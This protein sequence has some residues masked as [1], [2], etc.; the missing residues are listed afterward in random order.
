MTNYS[1]QSVG[2]IFIITGSVTYNIL[3]IGFTVIDMDVLDNEQLLLVK[4]GLQ[5]NYLVSPD[6]VD[7]LAYIA[8]NAIESG[9][10]SP[11]QI[12]DSIGAIIIGQNGAQVTY[13]D[14]GNQIVIEVPTLDDKVDKV[15]G[16]GLSQNDYTD[17]IADL[18]EV[19]TRVFN[20][21]MSGAMGTGGDLTL[22]GGITFSVSA[23][24]GYAK[25]PLDNTILI[26]WTDPI[27]GSAVANGDNF[28]YIN[29][30]GQIVQ[31]STR[32][33]ANH[34]YV[35]YIRTGF[36]NTQVVGYS[37]VKFTIKD[38]Y[39]HLSK[40]I[41]T[42]IGTIVE[43]GCNLSLQA[44]PNNLKVTL[45]SGILWI[46]LTDKA[47]PDA[48]TFTKLFE[49]SDFGFI[50]DTVTAANTINNAY[51]NVRT[52]DHLTALVPMTTGY[53]KK[54]LFFITPE[55]ALYYVYAT[56]EYATGELAIAA[57]I[58][59]VPEQIKHSVARVG[60]VIIQQGATSV[61]DIYD[62]RPMFSKLFQTGTPSSPTTVINHGD[63][64]G[65]NDDDHG[66]Y[67]TDAR[68]DIRYNTK[69]EITSFLAGKAN[70]AHAHVIADV[71]GLQTALNDKA[72]SVHT[73]VIAD[74][75]GLQTELNG[76]EA[77]ITATTSADYYRGDKTFAT[78][79]KAAVGLENVINADT[80][81]TANITDSANKRFVTD[82]Q[83]TVLGNT[84]GTNTGDETTGTIKTKL[85]I[86]SGIA[87]GY[88]T[89]ANFTTFNGK[90]DAITAGT[91][92]QYY[93]GDKTFQTL[94]KT[95]VGL[96]S[97]VNIDTTTTANITDSTDK[98]FVTNAHLVILG[99]TSNTNT[100][101]E[102]Q[103]T[104]KTKLGAASTLV[105]GYLTTADWDTFNNKE[106]AITATA[107]TDYYRGDKTFQTL[108]KTAVGLANVDN[109]TD[110]SK[111][112]ST[113]TQT[114]L[115]AKE[116]TITAGTTGQ[117]W[118]GDKSWQTLDKTAVDLA[119]VDNTSDA[120]KPIS[121]LTQTAL[122]AKEPTVT[123]GTT[124]QYYRGDKSFQTLN[125]AAVGLG[126]V[127]N[128]DATNA[129]NISS[130]TL[131][132]ARLS[133]NLTEIGDETFANGEIIQSFSGVLQNASLGVGTTGAVQ[134]T[135]SAGSI[136]FDAPYAKG[137]LNQKSGFFEDFITYSSTT[138]SPILARSVT[139]LNA[140]TSIGPA[141]SSNDTRNGIIVFTTGTTASGKSACASGGNLSNI[142]F[143]NI[144]IG[145]YEEVGFRFTI[146]TV[147]DATQSFQV[148]AGFGDASYGVPPTDGAYISVGAGTVG[149]QAN[150]SSNSTKTYSG[151]LLATVANTDY[152]VRIRVSNIAGTLSAS[153]FVNGTQLG[154]DITTNI[155]KGAGR[156]LGISFGIVKLAGITART[157]ELDWIY[158]ESFK[159]RTINY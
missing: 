143:A 27:T 64:I 35:G 117:Y 81:T 43:E 133:A 88:L 67:H 87:D 18:V 158:H 100:G 21:T 99:N 104:I 57:S 96:G 94:D 154:T 132:N 32:D 153:Y 19:K 108:D 83:S 40:F 126:S 138:I 157:V 152:V 22:T 106:G 127:P 33:S 26:E 58:P 10:T 128:V 112:I 42:G 114:A 150:T 141:L 139:G 53:Y 73:H 61:V 90:E 62:I 15:T 105:D 2:P 69:A 113:L 55:G 74:T 98:R 41:T 28:I 118:R 3:N 140:G 155:P 48:S 66:L 71:T 78:L 93:R 17:E 131:A 149:F 36:G 146:P 68:G 151:S 156:D 84:S 130:G 95:A 44:F 92:G 76:K 119:N 72:A 12:A 122:N 97:V 102:T 65:L 115:N 120:S 136:L 125:S 46:D 30:L 77:T 103:A 60:A 54:D 82:T 39:F 56:E 145:G 9:T 31:Q 47:I 111:P 4:K 63:L 135:N 121:T 148:I 116:S 52:N 59:Q 1:F 14:N 50:P 38:Y 8:S 29:Y 5:Y 16:Y 142:N 144:P 51:I 37:P 85:G 34:I 134:I 86:A 124:G 137:P 89:A 13:D 101:D 20:D 6:S 80:T 24:Y 109:T 45:G 7:V 110:A 159:P 23:G 107:S 129:S 79:N 25:D 49:T 75:T 123:A 91:S 147:S 11:E 70:T